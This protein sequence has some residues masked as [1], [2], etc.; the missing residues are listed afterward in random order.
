MACRDL[1]TSQGLLVRDHDDGEHE[2][3]GAGNLAGR[4]ACI[5]QGS[6][7]GQALR[8]PSFGWPERT[9]TPN[10]ALPYESPST[11]R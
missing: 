11:A 10:R 7:S 9:P 6:D 2:V 3:A 4:T 5:V 1:N 8:A